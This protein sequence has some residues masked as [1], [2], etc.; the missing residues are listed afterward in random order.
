MSER[1]ALAEDRSRLRS[2]AAAL[3]DVWM[4]TESDRQYKRVLL[5]LSLIYI[6]V[7]LGIRLGPL[8]TEGGKL[9]LQDK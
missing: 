6:A 8:L 1:I 3:V 4:Q 7:I 9:Q 2:R 5:P